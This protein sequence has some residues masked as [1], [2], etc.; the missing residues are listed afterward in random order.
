MATTPAPLTPPYATI[1]SRLSNVAMKIGNRQDVLQPAPA[2]GFTYSRVAGW[3]RDAYIAI[4]TCRSFE[5]TEFT[6]TF[7]TV[8]GCDTYVLPAQL[9]APKAFTGYDQYGTPIQID[10]KDMAY[11]RRYNAGTQ[12]QGVPTQ[13]RPSIWTL[14]NNKVILRPVPDQSTYTFYFDYWQ[15]PLITPDVVSTPLL[16]P[17]EWLEVVD[18]EAAIRGNA[19]LQQAD[20]SHEM[21]ELLYGYTDPVT[22]RFVQGLIERLQ[23][24][25]QAMAPF[26]DYGLQP[27]YS[28]GYTR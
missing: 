5:Q 3:L 14:W 22:R 8:Q 24:R 27:S 9:R 17:D 18:Y 6:Y 28:G 1:E 16:L 20:R 26:V 11:I 4:A 19:E 10:Y 12:S 21:Q 2:S 15:R 13:A 25:T 7:N 23:N